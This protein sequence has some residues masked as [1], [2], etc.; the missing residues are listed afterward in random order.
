MEPP[1]T[2]RRCRNCNAPLP[3]YSGVGRPRLY[4]TPA[5]RQVRKTTRKALPVRNT[6]DIVG[7]RG[8]GLTYQVI[9]ALVGLSHERVRQLLA[10]TGDNGPLS[11]VGC[12]RSIRGGNFTACAL[13]A[14]SQSRGLGRRDGLSALSAEWGLASRGGRLKSRG[15]I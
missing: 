14:G 9:G 1:E 13:A 10:K 4:C 6:D 7:L 11:C 8:Q 15:T 12:G 2:S 5:C 3:P